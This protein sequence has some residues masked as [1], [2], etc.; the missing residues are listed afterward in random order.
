M[1]A[2]SLLP[3]H[4]TS[5]VSRQVAD[6]ATK[7][8]CKIVVFGRF[9]GKPLSTELSYYIKVPPERHDPSEIKDYPANEVLI[10]CAR[11]PRGTCGIVRSLTEPTARCNCTGWY[12]YSLSSS[13]FLEYKLVWIN[14]S[15]FEAGVDVIHGKINNIHT[16]GHGGQQEQSSCC[17]WSNPNT[18]MPVHGEYCMQKIH[19]G[20]ARDCGS[21]ER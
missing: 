11:Q 16:S 6:A 5:S 17:A 19:A 12:R 14:W 1:D 15:S 18:L 7:S 13:P 3:L 9:D 20:L 21:R 10:M 2:S 4:P 8:G